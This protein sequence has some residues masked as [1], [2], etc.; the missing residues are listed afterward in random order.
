MPDTNAQETKEKDPVEGIRTALN[1]ALG[2]L[3]KLLGRE[4]EE[5]GEVEGEIQRDKPQDD[6]PTGGVGT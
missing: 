1:Q 3:K 5:L 4:E 2:F 6:Q